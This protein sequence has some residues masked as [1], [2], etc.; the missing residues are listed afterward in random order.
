MEASSQLHPR[1]SIFGKITHVPIR[2]VG[3][4]KP[5]A[6]LDVI[7]KYEILVTVVDLTLFRTTNI[8]L[9]VTKY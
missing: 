8:L 6:D 7:F 2:I 5:S 3:W 9:E 4:V 1:R